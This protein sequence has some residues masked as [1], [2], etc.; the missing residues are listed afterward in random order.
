MNCSFIR[1]I[2]M[3]SEVVSCVFILKL[4]F[5]IADSNTE[6]TVS[7]EKYPLAIKMMFNYEAESNAP[8]I[9]RAMYKEMLPARSL[10]L[11]EAQIEW[12]E[13]LL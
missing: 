6:D 1:P 3:I 7:L 2:F 4:F 8:A 9:L 13:R 5:A 12:Q 11:D 10:Q